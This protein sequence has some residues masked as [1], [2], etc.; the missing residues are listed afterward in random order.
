MIETLKSLFQLHADLKC[1]SLKVWDSK[2]F[3]KPDVN[4]LF[5]LISLSSLSQIKME[6]LNKFSEKWG[7]QSNEELD[8]ALLYNILDVDKDGKVSRV[9]FERFL[10]C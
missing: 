9:D 5:D 3:C 4:K 1:V 2:I 7:V 8:L 10:G 6:D